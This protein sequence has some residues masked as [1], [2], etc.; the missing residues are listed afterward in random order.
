MIILICDI[1]VLVQS[2]Y[3]CYSLPLSATNPAFLSYIVMTSSDGTGLIV[4]E[5]ETP[6]SVS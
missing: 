1:F 5:S 6:S 3:K 4:L 2:Q